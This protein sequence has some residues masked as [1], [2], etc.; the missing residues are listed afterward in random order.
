MLLQ[1]YNL[2]KLGDLMIKLSSGNVE[3]TFYEIYC[4]NFSDKG[5]NDMAIMHCSG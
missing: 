3:S 2:R 4:K 1:R 5:V